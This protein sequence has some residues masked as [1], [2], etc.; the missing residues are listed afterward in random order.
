MINKR[1]LLFGAASLTITAAAGSAAA[2]PKRRLLVAGQSLAG[3][4][5]P[6]S[7]V[8]FE[9][10]KE[11]RRAMGDPA[12]WE[13]VVAAIGGSAALKEHALASAPD[14]WW[15]DVDV[16][17]GANWHGPALT[18]ALDI[19]QDQV[20]TDVVWIQG[21]ADASRW[22]SAEYNEWTLKNRYCRAFRRIAGVL[23]PYPGKVRINVLEYM[24]SQ[25]AG[26]EIIRQAHI[27]LIADDYA[28]QGSDPDPLLVKWDGLHPSHTAGCAQMGVSTARSITP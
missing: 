4:W 18:Q 14:K 26:E 9:A 21:Q 10:F 12:E 2:A 7:P 19:V 1:T 25:P 24:D 23:F 11:T 27:D 22:T 28:L 17:M 5:K 8:T 20:F 6:W 16:P 3:Y 13:L 15:C